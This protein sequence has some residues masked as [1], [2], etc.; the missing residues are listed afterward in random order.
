MKLLSFTKYSYEGP[1]SRYRF[2]NYVNC[3]AK[4]NISLHIEPFFSSAYLKKN[5]IGKKTFYVLTAYLQRMFKLIILLS[6]P[7]QYDLVLIEYELF[8]YFPAVFEK[9]LHLRGIRYIV[10]YDDAI[11]HKYD[12]HENVVVRWFL[13][14]KIGQIMHDA[15]AVV[16]CNP[17]LEMY[18][19][20]YNNDTFRLPTVV[21]LDKY[22]TIM[23][24]YKRDDAQVFTIGWIGS[25][26]TSAYVVEI[27]PAM[28]KFASKHEVQF[29]LVGFD[30]SL[31][32]DEMR[33][34]CHINMVPWSEE[35]EVEG[36]LTFDVGIMP[37]KDDAWARG[38]CG[39]KLVQYMS[40]KKPV[41]ASP[42]G[43]NSSLVIDGKNGFLAETVD[44]WV[45]AFERVYL[46][47]Q[48]RVK[49]GDTNFQKVER[50]FNHQINC[51]KYVGLIRETVKKSKSSTDYAD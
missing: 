7:K 37:L 51:K 48:L 23:D 29:N 38:K 33:K 31:V 30:D 49:M 35:S 39:F 9:L 45:S 27:L 24:K 46:D 47:E 5:N 20:Q 14:E 50:E 26:S 1:S 17:Y 21:L 41:I 28:E 18:A 2:Y 43:M 44:E 19:K 34:R 4:E 22:K 10:D 16:V 25:K 8:P 15:E 6:M 42:V 40:C 32:N 36:I 13:K 11:F 12:Q 3:F